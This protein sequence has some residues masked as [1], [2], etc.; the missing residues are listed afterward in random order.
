M[1]D[2]GGRRVFGHAGIMAPAGYV[3]ARITAQV[4]GGAYGPQY[5]VSP[6]EF[7]GVGV[8][9]VVG[10]GSGVA[11]LAYPVD[12]LAA[13]AAQPV[14]AV[15]LAQVC[16]FD[17]RCLGVELGLRLPR[18]LGVEQPVNACERGQQCGQHDQQQYGTEAKQGAQ[19]YRHS[20]RR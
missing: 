11:L 15:E 1:A 20:P 4:Y 18:H 5:A 6:A 3:E 10:V 17:K 7:V 19:F 13:A 12:E 8:V 2:G 14:L 9:V 16:R